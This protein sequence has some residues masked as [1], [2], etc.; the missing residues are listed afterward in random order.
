MTIAVERTRFSAVGSTPHVMANPDEECSVI[1]ATPSNAPRLW[2]EYLDGARA[3]YRRYG[4]GA[5]LDI[6]AVIDGRQTT[7]FAA[8]VDRDGKVVGGLRV[9]GP[10]LA[11][12]ESHALLEWAPGAGRETLRSVID[13]RIADGVIEVKT[14][15][16]DDRSPSARAIAAQMSRTS[17]LLLDI[18]N[19]RYLMATAAEHV[20]RLWSTGGGR[21]AE[22]V[23]STPYPDERYSTRLMLWDRRTMTDDADPAVWQMMLRE[24]EMLVPLES[25]A[26][27]VA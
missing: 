16:G 9:Q 25:S 26:V 6:S 5:A 18:S 17:M 2:R 11:S 27:L 23:P 21:V 24:A 19:A 20:L 15:W 7:F 8:V 13:E 12:G 22:S 3:A 4:C 1:F 14:A 10:F